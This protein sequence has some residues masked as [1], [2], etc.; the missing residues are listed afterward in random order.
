VVRYGKGQKFNCSR[1]QKLMNAK[2]EEEV[3][4]QEY[5]AA[6][7]GTLA[8]RLS[9]EIKGAVK[10]LG[11]NRYKLVVQ[12]TVGQRIGQSQHIISRCLWDK[13]SDGSASASIETE[14]MFCSASCYALYYE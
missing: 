10:H 11:Y 8:K 6:T 2:L 5:N 14:T 12:V 7:A 13:G 1:V 9:D 3:K 4:G